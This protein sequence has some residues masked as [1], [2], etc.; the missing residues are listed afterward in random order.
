MSKIRKPQIEPLDGSEHGN[1]VDLSVDRAEDDKIIDPLPEETASYVARAKNTRSDE[2]YAISEDYESLTEDTV[3][4]DVDRQDYDLPL[5]AENSEQ[6]NH[7]KRVMPLSDEDNPDIKR[8]RADIRTP[9]AKNYPG[10]EHGDTRQ[11]SFGDYDSQ[12]DPG[13]PD[14][15]DYYS[16]ESFTERYGLEAQAQMK[17]NSLLQTGHNI[18]RTGLSEGNLD[19]DSQIKTGARVYHLKGY[20]TVDKI[21]REFRRESRE[22]KIRNILTILVI[23]IFVVIMLVIYNPIKD[24]SEWRKILGLDSIYA[25]QTTSTSGETIGDIEGDILPPGITVPTLD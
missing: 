23:I 21:K 2:G 3:F 17:K 4:Y 25:E 18:L 11:A 7:T 9:G 20:T 12:G 15:Q 1:A 13:D 24:F 8:M 19:L 16:R 14:R 10:F 22:K 5:S 6:P